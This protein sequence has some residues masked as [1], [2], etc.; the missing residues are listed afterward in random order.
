MGKIDARSRHPSQRGFSDSPPVFRVTNE[1][2]GEAVP[3]NCVWTRELIDL[4][5]INRSANTPKNLRTYLGFLACDLMLVV[6]A[7]TCRL[8]AHSATY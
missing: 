5:W 8:S 2:A 3:A 6:S 1:K 7:G 4:V